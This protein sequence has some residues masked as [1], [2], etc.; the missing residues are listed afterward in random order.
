[1]INRTAK[2]DMA[3]GCTAPVLYEPYI[4]EA[5]LLHSDKGTFPAIAPSLKFIDQ[6]VGEW[7][8]RRTNPFSEKVQIYSYNSEGQSVLNASVYLL[9]SISPNHNTVQCQVTDGRQYVT[10][11][12][13]DDTTRFVTLVCLRL[14]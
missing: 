10:C 14:H 4:D 7:I 13:T 12:V 2:F 1:V 6:G 3:P 8:S 5:Y 9:Q 11:Q